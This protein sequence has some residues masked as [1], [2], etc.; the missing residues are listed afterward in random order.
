MP[1]IELQLNT[2]ISN[3]TI[4]RYHISDPAFLCTL[5]VLCVSAG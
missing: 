5:G 2:L 3:A 4:I 1:N